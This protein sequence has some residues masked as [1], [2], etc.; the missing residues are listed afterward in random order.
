VF[1][2]LENLVLHQAPFVDLDETGQLKRRF[3]AM[4]ESIMLVGVNGTGHG[5][6][7][8]NGRGPAS[9]SHEATGLIQQIKSG[10]RPSCF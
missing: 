8:R 3:S 2:V 1:Y 4:G 6:V 10:T 9:N 7:F 5:D